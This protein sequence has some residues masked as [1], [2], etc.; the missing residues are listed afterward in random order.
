[1]DVIRTVV[2]DRTLSPAEKVLFAILYCRSEGNECHLSV[3]ELVQLVGV[4][5]Q[6]LQKSLENLEQGGLIRLKE[7]CQITDASSFLS[8]AVLGEKFRPH[9]PDVPRP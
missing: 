4:E 3:E 8:C 7:D 2:E 6:A 1:M 5:L 9:E